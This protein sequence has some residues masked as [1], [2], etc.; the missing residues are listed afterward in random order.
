MSPFM[1]ADLDP[2]ES[3]ESSGLKELTPEQKERLTDVLDE[4][5][6]AL[7]VFQTNL[8]DLFDKLQQCVKCRLYGI[9]T[10]NG[11]ITMENLLQNFCI[12]NQTLTRRDQALEDHLRFG[13]VRMGRPYQ[14]HRN[15]GIDEDQD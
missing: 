2:S 14:V 1:A 9:V 6:C 3:F 12:G 10:I 8:V 4:Y 7:D 5:L 15:I 13:L 11:G